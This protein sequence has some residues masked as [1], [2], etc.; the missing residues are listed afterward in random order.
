MKNQTRE[1]ILSMPKYFVKLTDKMS[2]IIATAAAVI[3]G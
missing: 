2:A 1:N 3:T